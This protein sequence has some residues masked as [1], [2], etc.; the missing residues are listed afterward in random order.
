MTH[1][2]AKNKFVAIFLL[3]A[4]VGGGVVLPLRSAKAIFGAGDSVIIVGNPV[5][6][7]LWL[8]QIGEAIKTTTGII[9]DLV[10]DTITATGITALVKKE[11]VL[12]PLAN[13]IAKTIIRALTNTIVSWIQG[14]GNPMFVQDLGR[15]VLK[16]ADQVGGEFLNKLAGTNLCSGFNVDFRFNLTL[17]RIKR[18]SECTVSGII[19]AVKNT[20]F[21]KDIGVFYNDFEVNGAERGIET[22]LSLLDP[23]NSFTSS[24]D[25]AYY[26]K[27][28]L[29][30]QA[31]QK[32]IKIFDWGSGFKPFE[33]EETVDDPT[34]CI[35]A[36]GAS[37]GPS[38][39]KIKTGRTMTPGKVVAE[40]LQKSIDVGLDVG[41][42]A[43]ELDEAIISII[44]ALINKV[45]SGSIAGSSGGGLTND[46]LGSIGFDSSAGPT[47]NVPLQKVDDI[48]TLTKNAQSALNKKVADIDETTKK[49]NEEIVKLNEKIK[50]C[51][52]NPSSVD[53][54]EEKVN[55]IKSNKTALESK[56]GD[57]AKQLAEEKT[58]LDKLSLTLEHGVKIKNKLESA[59][60]SSEFAN[61]EQELVAVEEEIG[62]IVFNIENRPTPQLVDG[63]I[64]LIDT[65][66]KINKS[67]QIPDK[68]I[69]GSSSR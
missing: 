56:L 42:I 21:N 60:E 12:D 14:G 53:C 24:F 32:R 1:I 37:G 23:A 28:S 2:G 54:G 19:S 58:N 34:G 62:V 26:T 67:E 30:I 31:G 48:I 15:E 49:T 9:A 59:T 43:D 46:G 65:G 52:S 17:P 16:S 25:K 66:I 64:E 36:F 50:N 20:T 4:I 47:N 68:T 11:F 8:K 44:N 51:E 38:C 13:I 5:E 41:A 7:P 10:Q 40:T 27:A 3:L 61:L 57:L 33:F 63:K 55:Q 29:E 18:I 35:D 39:P 45:I 6:I 69:G 22:Y